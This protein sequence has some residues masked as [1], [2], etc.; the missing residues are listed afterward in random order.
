[1]PAWVSRRLHGW[2]IT[3]AFEATSRVIIWNR[4]SWPYEI[5][6][7]CL[8]SCL[9]G[10]ARVNSTPIAGRKHPRWT[11]SPTHETTCAILKFAS[12]LSRSREDAKPFSTYSSSRCPPGYPVDFMAGPLPTRSKRPFESSFGTGLHGP[13]K[14]LTSVFLRAF[15]ASREAIRLPLPDAS[16]LG[17]PFPPLTNDL[18]HLEVHF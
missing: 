12:R 15:A 5:S 14:S 18:R 13:T 8:S 9:R 6:D 17:G 16:I 10:F 3:N 2:T 4:S 1:M 11:M 7:F